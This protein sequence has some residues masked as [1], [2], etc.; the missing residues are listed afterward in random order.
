M[1]ILK[2]IYNLGVR[3]ERDRVKNLIAEFS[4]ETKYIYDNIELESSSRKAS[5][6]ELEVRFEAQR[7]LQK[8][9]E[10]DWAHTVN[11]PG[12]APIDRE[13]N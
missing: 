8:L 9:L 6:Q 13:T 3:H 4:L 7:L 11:Q 10:P 12:P 5:K 1:K 2:W